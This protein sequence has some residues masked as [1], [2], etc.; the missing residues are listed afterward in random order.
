MHR[1]PMLKTLLMVNIVSYGVTVDVQSNNIII[2]YHI[3]ILGDVYPNPPP[4]DSPQL[5]KR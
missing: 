2:G 1:L 4:S 3:T 5:E